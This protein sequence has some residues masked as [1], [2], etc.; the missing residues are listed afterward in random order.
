MNELTKTITLFLSCNALLLSHAEEAWSKLTGPHPS[1]VGWSVKGTRADDWKP[2]QDEGV[3]TLNADRLLVS[4]GP[5]TTASW[6]ITTEPI[7][8]YQYSE[9]RVR[10]RAKG[11]VNKDRFPLLVLR[12]GSTGPVTPGATN[13]ENPLARAGEGRVLPE[14]EQLRDG[15]IHEITVP[16]SPPIQTEQ[17]DQIVLTTQTGSQPGRLEILDL[18]FC[19]PQL[20][21]D[22]QVVSF[23]NVT[24]AALNSDLRDH[25]FV[26]LPESNVTLEQIT[27]RSY[28]S[29]ER[30]VCANTIFEI[31]LSKTVLCTGMMDRGEIALEVDESCSEIYLLLGASLVGADGGFRFQPRSEITQPERI[32]VTKRYADGLV[33]R[34][35]PYNLNLND[36]VVSATASNYLIPADPQNVLKSVTI[37]ERMSYGQIFL[38]GVTINRDL[39]APS[40]L[41][42]PDYPMS[43]PYTQA[44]I[45]ESQPIL[46]A[47]EDKKFR[48]ENAYYRLEIS[49]E[50]GFYLTSCVHKLIHKDLLR[51]PTPLLGLQIDESLVSPEDLH[52][53]SYKADNQSLEF[54]IRIRESPG[55]LHIATQFE[56]D[57]SSECKM[58][59][60][61]KNSGTS[62][63]SISFR[64][65]DVHGLH[66]NDDIHDDYYM[67]PG[68]KA[69]HGNEFVQLTGDPG[70]FPLQFMDLYSEQLSCGVALHTRNT[71]PILRRYVLD[72][73]AGGTRFAIE[74]GHDL[75]IQLEPGETF[76]AAPTVIQFHAGDWRV[77]F[78]SY[79]QWTRSWYRI[80]SNARDVLKNV[81]ICRRDYPIGGTGY[82]FDL[83]NNTYIFSRLIDES[84]EDLGGVDMIDISGWAYSEDHG[85]VGQYRDYEL[86]GRENLR[87]G[88]EKS[89]RSG[90]PVGFYFE[91][92]LVDPRSD[93][94]KQHGESWQI[95]NRQGKPM[96]W[97]GNTEMFMCPYIEEWRSFMKSTLTA[98]AQET[99]V[100]AVYLDQFGLAD[101]SKTCFSENHGHAAGAHPLQGE[102]GMFQ[103]VRE[104][105]NQL[106][107]PVALYT[108]H[109]PNDITSQY[110][111]ASFAYGMWRK[112]DY[113]SPTKL[114][115]FHYAFPSFKVIELFHP[116]I[117]PKGIS[118]EDAKLCF[119]HGHAMWLK[120]RARSWYSREC[121]DF[122][123]KAYR[124]YH[125]HESAFTSENI[126]PH[127]PT[128]QRGLYAN[129][130]S[131]GKEHVITL[132]NAWYHTMRGEL[133]KWP[134][135]AVAVKDLWG[136]EDFT[137]TQ[138]SDGIQ[139]EGTLDPHQVAC[140]SIER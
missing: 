131:S 43:L 102:H 51:G 19:D 48:I 9:L 82:L 136:I 44:E 7:W 53:E 94:G 77:P 6:I 29:Y 36:Y 46:Q 137:V 18:L 67:F 114:N 65:P 41:T 134:G 50:N 122:I 5:N 32:L 72:K 56:A 139:I 22:S 97:T 123:K 20:S 140:V 8:V 17:I 78:R 40:R 14:S 112:G 85:R 11:L 64:F 109:V 126:E 58:T 42:E 99:N 80:H 63:R 73:D 70:L 3:L 128:L 96:Q 68:K 59:L 28:K 118:A 74:Y 119:L 107:R 125:E 71:E 30:V 81:F 117:D 105:L 38:A 4:T 24:P 84:R 49:T 33:E 25:K 75:P 121:R 103:E 101:A 93:I 13:M 16:V 90:V 62:R 120:G 26:T 69:A 35:F 47:M 61:L 2:L 1:T 113:T 100:D 12:S 45:E 52:L 124:I 15:E 127:I 83:F 76:H 129:R 92:Y 133:L 89:R 23:E 111:D 95:I 106:D 110:V 54:Q 116:G 39:N 138:V 31:N 135:E 108:E 130:F 115:L 10:F 86:G 87:E 104:A 21:P 27:G 88:I 132:Y 60:Q 66:I 79:V 55:P 91:G 34:S 37:E 57:R 98:V